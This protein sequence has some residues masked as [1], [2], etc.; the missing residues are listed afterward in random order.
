MFFD[1]WGTVVENGIFP[2]PVRQA[3]RI[4]R[5][6]VPFPEYIQKFESSFMTKKFD[7]LTEYFRNVTKEFGT[8]PPEFVYEKLVGMW[9]KNTILCKPFPETIE[10][11]DE[12]KKDY[13]L[14]LISNTDCLSV[15]QLLEKFDLN[16]YFDEVVLSCDIGSLKTDKEIFEMPLKKLKLKKTEVIMVG[17]SIP[18]DIEGAAK[19]GIAGILVDRRGT[20]EFENKIS[21]LTELKEKLENE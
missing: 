8:N 10:V 15:P 14:V 4:L 6:N 16:K 7:T 17:D 13:K 5:I 19:A 9:N 21:S 11:L 1:F 2:S 20:R 12:L 3:Q 18:T